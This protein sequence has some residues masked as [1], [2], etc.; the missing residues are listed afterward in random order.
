MTAQLGELAQTQGVTWRPDDFE[1]GDTVEILT[2]TLRRSQRRGTF[3]GLFNPFLAR[4]ET[5]NGR[6]AAID[7][8]RLL[9]LTG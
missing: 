5:A 6:R 9:K 2:P 7:V 4:V 8:D 1:P 3:V